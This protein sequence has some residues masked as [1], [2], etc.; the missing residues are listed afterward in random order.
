MG[1]YLWNL[2]ENHEDRF[3]D[4]VPYVRPWRFNQDD[5]Y[6]MFVGPPPYGLDFPWET[7]G[8]TGNPLDGSLTLNRGVDTQ[9]DT[10]TYLYVST[11]KTV[12]LTGEGDCVPRWFLNYQFDSPQEFVVGAA[13]DIS[14]SA[15][16]NRLDI[17]GYNQNRGFLFETSALASQ[18]DIM[19]TS[20]VPEPSTICGLAL[21]A[22]TGGLVWLIRR[23]RTAL[24]LL[25]VLPCLISIANAETIGN[26]LWN[27][28]ENS[29]SF[30]GANV[31]YVRPWRGAYDDGWGIFVGPPPYGGPF[32]WETNSTTGNA[33]DG[34]LSINRG[35]DHQF[36][37]WTYLYVST[38][39]SISLSGQGD[40]VPRWFLNYA[41][42]SPQQFPLGGAASIN[43]SAGWN[44]L[45]ITGYNQ[46]SDFLFESGP[47]ASQV[48]I[49]NTAPVPEPSTICAIVSML[50]TGRLF[51]VIR[52]RSA[53]RGRLQR[54]EDGRLS[55]R[56][57]R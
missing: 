39:E 13:T 40:C 2:R 25:A 50:A 33:L 51:L 53:R 4:N 22:A 57:M 26:H 5:G 37:A 44:R 55:S 20:A 16:W 1:N 30:F 56:C 41:F 6:G 23:C 42:D 28:R 43:L 11:P 49:M 35:A 3:H 48:N 46:I 31:P 17:T 8:T 38:A 34:S 32:L 36:H 9:F 45:D 10:W 29:E 19:N 52:R 14:L 27:L 24:A 18:V 12:S 21:L 7:M 47:L 15:G 54:M